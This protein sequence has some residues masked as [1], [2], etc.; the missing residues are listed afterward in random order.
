MVF[1]GD[2]FVVQ[3]HGFG[4]LVRVLLILRTRGYSNRY[5]RSVIADKFSIEPVKVSKI[6]LI[7][8]GQHPRRS[9]PTLHPQVTSN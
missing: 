8:R 5:I 9:S 6:R 7:C 3:D 1:V 4:A 2:I